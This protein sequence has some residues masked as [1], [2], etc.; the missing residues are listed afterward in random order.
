MKSFRK[1]I[2]STAV[3]TMITISSV[4]TGVGVVSA[5]TPE[6]QV[7][8]SIKG[9]ENQKAKLNLSKVTD[10]VSGMTNADGGVMEIVDYNEKTQWAYAINGQAGCLTAISMEDM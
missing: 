6:I 10:Y 5:E 9:F 3:A 7:Q 8:E 1:R 4:C 2:I